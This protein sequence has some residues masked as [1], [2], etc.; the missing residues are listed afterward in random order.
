[1]ERGI[2]VQITGATTRT[3]PGGLGQS[4]A[5]F[6]W[7]SAQTALVNLAGA[8][9][10]VH[11]NLKVLQ[12]S[13]N[14]SCSSGNYRSL[15]FAAPASGTNTITIDG[16][17]IGSGNTSIN[18]N[19]GTG[20]T[21][22][23]NVGGNFNFTGG[24]FMSQNGSGGAT[25]STLNFTGAGKTFSEAATGNGTGGTG[26][27]WLEFTCGNAVMSN[28]GFHVNNL[29]SMTMNSDFP[30]LTTSTFSTDNGGTLNTGTYT[31]T[32][33]SFTLASGGTLS[34]GSTAGITSS[35]ATGNI[36]T[37]TRNYNTGAN[38]T[39][40]GSSA[41]VTGN[42]L[43]ASVN[44][45]T[46]NNASGVTLT[47]STTVTGA[48]NIT[49]G[50]FDQGSANNLAAGSIS[51]SSGATFRNTGTGAITLNGNLTNNGAVLID[52]GGSGCRDTD[53]HISITVT[54]SR[55]WSGTGA[56]QLWNVNLVNQT[57]SLG[58]YAFGG[59]CNVVSHPPEVS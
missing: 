2:E 15:A 8:L 10:T 46:I 41:Q 26:G 35:G 33:N 37:T 28:V 25:V 45:L 5:N 53:S 17:F 13:A 23:V 18:L 7:N 4:F 16:D 48:L 58:I 30:L 39:Y 49:A 20:G 38:Y 59:Q 24:Y 19:R 34:I 11:G 51:V 1:M 22:V 44:N 6:T 36:Q 27:G 3:A 32:G 43:P 12:T 47:D 31:V 56:F 9:T 29:G 14:T 21:V 50:V 55:T 42:G 57:T 54:G 52:G 40:S